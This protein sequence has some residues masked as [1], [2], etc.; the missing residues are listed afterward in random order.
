M[1]AGADWISLAQDRDRLRAFVNA[2]M[3]LPC[4]EFLDY[5]RN[6]QLLRMDS[7]PWN[8]LFGTFSLVGPVLKRLNPRAPFVYENKFHLCVCLPGG[9]L[10]LGSLTNFVL[11]CISICIS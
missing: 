1:G 8:K 5:L 10:H 11:I 4:G 9:V 3:N 2:V 7:A 6:C